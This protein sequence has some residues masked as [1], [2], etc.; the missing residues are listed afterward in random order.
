MSLKVTTPLITPDPDTTLQV[1]EKLYISSDSD[2]VVNLVIDTGGRPDPG[3]NE[4][5]LGTRGLNVR[6]ARRLVHF[7]GERH[8]PL[9]RAVFIGSDDTETLMEMAEGIALL[10]DASD[11]DAIIERIA[12]TLETLSAEAEDDERVSYQEFLG[13]YGELYTLRDAVEECA[14]EEEVGVVLEA[15]AFLGDHIHDWEPEGGSPIDV[16]ST[17]KSE[18]LEVFVNSR[19]Q[20]V[21]ED[22][23]ASLMVLSFRNCGPLSEGAMTLRDLVDEI[24]SSMDSVQRSL[25]RGSERLATMLASNHSERSL[26]IRTSRPPCVIRI[27]EIPDRVHLLAMEW[28]RHPTLA[29]PIR[30]TG[31]H[32]LDEN[33]YEVAIDSLRVGGA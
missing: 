4:S 6:V 31:Y 3:F 7:P 33:A 26:A 19:E 12:R 27:H 10:D 18:Q 9:H 5:G 30:L 32:A 13:L 1:N 29:K 11:Y 14:T 2:G 24:E 21:T 20:L 28:D 25:F 17:I 16:K 23:H 15:A 8:P 22:P